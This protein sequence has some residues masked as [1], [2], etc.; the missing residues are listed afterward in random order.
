[1]LRPFARKREENGV[2]E[3]TERS[4]K[5]GRR[6]GNEPEIVFESQ[7]EFD[8]VLAKRIEQ[9]RNKWIHENEALLRIGQWFMARDKGL[10][11]E[12]AEKWDGEEDYQRLADKLN[13]SP[14]TADLIFASG[15]AE[16]EG[17]EE[18]EGG[19][20]PERLSARQMEALFQ[21]EAEIQEKLPGFDLVEFAGANEMTAALIA[22]GFPLK[23]I[24]EQFGGE[25]RMKQVREEAQNEVLERIR[26]RNAMPAPLA[27]YGQAE[28]ESGV[29]GMSDAQIESIDR[30]V[31]AGKRVIL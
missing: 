19:R 24:V 6:M 7:A 28:I 14:K 5:E 3:E 1:M 12:E 18:N 10:E 23:D 2:I 27:G 21:Q 30:A 9:E 31:R 4:K 26:A 25:L 16:T 8:R 15:Q 11:P 17:T 22:L 20:L 29:H 13:V